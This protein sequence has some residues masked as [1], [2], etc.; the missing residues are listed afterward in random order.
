M[1]CGSD[2]FGNTKC[3]ILSRHLLNSLQVFRIVKQSLTCR[4]SQTEFGNEK[5]KLW[6]VV[7]GEVIRTFNG[8][9]GDIITSIAIATDGRTALSGSDDKTLKL[10][11]L[12]T[13]KEIWT[14][15]G[16]NEVVR[17]VVIAPDGRTALSSSDDGMLIEPI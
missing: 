3:L 17:L 12:A 13:G 2:N 10:W 7:T 14:F 8:Q 1:N 5:I 11:D 4:H 9:H 6:D 16:H 15:K